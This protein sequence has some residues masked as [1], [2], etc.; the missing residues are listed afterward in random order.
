MSEASYEVG[1]AVALRCSFDL[2]YRRSDRPR[3]LTPGWMSGGDIDNAYRPDD[4]ASGEWIWED[5]RPDVPSDPTVHQWETHFASMAISE[6]V[7]EALEWFRV[8]G[9]PWLD[10]HGDQEP[11]I[12]DS[13]RALVESLAALRARE[14]SPRG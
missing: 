6:A 1:C 8:D 13:V 14:E 4:K 9:K 10:P 12:Y 2:T 5:D 3:Q 7:H 11:R